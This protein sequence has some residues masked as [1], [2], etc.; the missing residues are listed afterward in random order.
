MKISKYTLLVILI[1][2]VLFIIPF[3]WLKP[4]E[5]DLGGDSSR[6]YFYDPFSYLLAQP[7]YNIASSGIGGEAVSYYA[8][9]FYLLLILL[10]IVSSPTFVIALFNGLTLSIAFISCYFIVKE[11][12]KG[13]SFR[14]FIIEISAIVAGLFY[15][16]SPV[17]AYSGWDKAILSH[18][19]IFLNPLMFFLLLRYFTT[20]NIHYL[21][22]LLFISF[23]FS[24]NFSYA[25]APPFLAFYPISIFFL[26]LYTKFIRKTPIP[27]KGLFTGGVLFFLLNAFHL[28]PHIFGVLSFG[29]AVSASVFSEKTILSRGLD[30]FTAIAPSIKVSI[31]FLNLV[32]RYELVPLSFAFIIFPFIIILAFLQKESKNKTLL[33]LGIFFLIVVF[34]ETANITDLGFNIYKGLFYIPGFKVFRNYF[35]QW[36]YTYEFF[37]TLLLGQSLAIVLGHSKKIYR[38]MIVISIFFVLGT[39]TWPLLSGKL[40]NGFNWQTK[41]V[42]TVI[43]MD[44][45]YVKALGFAKDYKTD[46]KI[47]SFPLT[48]PGYQVLADN[49]GGAYVGPPTFSYLEGRSDF[50]GYE[51]LFPVNEIFLQAA[52]NKDFKVLQKL[53]SILNIRYVFH[54]SD[55]RIYDNT[56]TGFPYDYVRDFLPINQ[57]TY[58]TFIEQLP[59]DAKIDFGDKYHFYHISDDVFLPHIFTTANTIYTNDPLHFQFITKFNQERRSVVLGLEARNSKEGTIYLEAKNINPLNDL[60]KNEHLHEHKPFVSL[61]PK[62]VFYQL[63]LLREKFDL[64]RAEKKYNKYVDLALL[65]LPKRIFELDKWGNDMPIL[66][67]EWKEPKLWEYY[68]WKSYYSWESSFTRYESAARAFIRVVNNS[69]ESVNWKEVAFIKLKEQ[70]YQHQLHVTLYI[71]DLQIGEEDKKYLLFLENRIFN[72]LMNETNAEVND[73]RTIPYTLDIP[74]GQKGEYEVFLENKDSV[75]QDSTIMIGD[76]LLV[77]L[78]SKIADD[79]IQ[80]DNVVISDENEIKFNLHNSPQ[81]IISHETWK[82]SGQVNMEETSSVLNVYNL[83]GNKQTGVAKD[84]GVFKEIH[85]LKPGKQ[86]LISFD[87]LTFGED[88]I[89]SFY[90]KY[91]KNDDKKVFVANEV[92]QRLLNSGTWKN[93]QA[94]ITTSINIDHGI[95]QFTG[96]NGKINSDMQIKNLSVTEVVY[97]KIFFKKI[98]ENKTTIPPSIVFTKIN[99]TKYQIHVTNV[100]N[101]YTLVFLESFSANWK[102]IDPQTDAASISSSIARIFGAIGKSLT[103]MIIKD[104]P[105]RETITESHFGGDI[106]EGV[107][108]NIF[109]EPGTFESW[110]KKT[111]AQNNHFRADG[112]ANAWNIDPSDLNGKTEYTL[113][114]EM[115]TQKQFY[116]FL[117]IS[118]LTA[119][120]VSLFFLLHVIKKNGKKQ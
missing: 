51:S 38:Y 89:F 22:G 87:Y 117:P 11:L 37:Y 62:H 6:L 110:G 30:Y 47:L 82:S 42:K 13:E 17:L 2:V 109:L 12:N 100:R 70:L 118:L 26:F 53:L 65:N 59:V 46:G 103:S 56:F 10:R 23:V 5:M 35:A 76:K 93:H 28:V 48:G 63:A 114:L 25:A 64:W 97:P 75:G 61:N 41:D 85:E 102:L 88:F 9:P 119:F 120:L 7:L 18:I 8:I 14:S 112:Y 68:K 66:R 116:I 4:G 1:T 111:I 86:Y 104:N 78:T 92:L 79:Y 101:P 43:Q 31:S 107:H 83:I 96:S 71:N 81:N 20:R 55:T 40:V 34:F 115:S 27:V 77:P 39:A 91:Y 44:P 84:T 15:T 106:K 29:S 69:P 49:H 80:F 16:F 99:P 50:N 52:S 108:R 36:L 21:L 24:L 95:I 57:N 3:F 32:Q 58:K 74:S 113:I 105:N 54:N 98:T 19:Q 33:L 90:E 94:I 72:D 60:L 73:F 45:E 67:E